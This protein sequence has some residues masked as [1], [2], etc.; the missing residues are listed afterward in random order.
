MNMALATGSLVQVSEREG[1]AYLTLNRPPLNI[2]NIAMMRELIDALDAVISE[3]SLRAVVLR[4]EGKGFSAGADITEQQG[5]TIEPLLETF[6]SL[7]LRLLQSPV[8]VVACVHG[9]ALGGG[10]EILLCADIVVAAEDARLGAPEIKL[11][12]FP[13]AAAVLLPRLVGMH[14]A[15]EMIL[16]GELFSGLEA[17]RLG[18]VNRAVPGEQLDQA[19]EL[20][21]DKLRGLSGA[22]LRRARRAIV[23][24]TMEPVEVALRKL[25]R[26]EIEELLPSA[27]AQEGFRAFLEKRP[28]IWRHQ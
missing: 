10:F 6:D 17:E 7:I 21:L 28:P 23:E 13:P 5:E 18:L 22:A 26:I 2:L 19:L 15:M 27:D 16:V 24:S 20:L 14:R 12:V 11:G 3:P 9:L 1:I 8:P 4:G 25:Q